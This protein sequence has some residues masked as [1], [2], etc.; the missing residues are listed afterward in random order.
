MLGEND[1]LNEYIKSLIESNP[2]IKKKLINKVSEAV[3]KSDL[4]ENIQGLLDDCIDN[5]D[6]NI[7]GVLKS[8]ITKKIKTGFNN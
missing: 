3:D 4:T 2:E 7:T 5:A 6:V 8:L 1:C